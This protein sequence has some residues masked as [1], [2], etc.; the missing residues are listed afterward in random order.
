LLNRA[1]SGF[2][3]FF[4]STN[5]FQGFDRPMPKLRFAN[6]LTARIVG[7]ARDRKANVAVIFA[8]AMVPTIY[9][10][11]MTLDYSQVI[12]KR[13]QL[14]A[15]ADAAVIA[16][17]TPTMLTQPTAN[18]VTAA[19]NVFNATASPQG[20]PLPGL[21]GTPALN[22][23]VTNSG[24][25]RTA[26]VSYTAAS[27]NNFPILLGT[28]V[29]AFNGSSS[30]SASGAPNINFYLLLDDS[31]SMAIAANQSDINTLMAATANNQDAP[32]GC[33]FACHQSNV[34]TT[35]NPKGEP[36]AAA[37]GGGDYLGIVNSQGKL[38]LNSQGLPFDNYALARSLSLTL[39]IDLVAQAVASLMTTAQATQLKN[40]NT[41]QAAIYT[42]DFGLNTI[43]APSGLPS[44]NLSAAG[45]QA[46]NNIQVPTVYAN[47]WL[48]SSNQNN[49]TNTNFSSALQ[50]LNT[51]M[52]NPGGGT[53]NKGDT[54]QEV[55]FLV[56]DGVE[57]KVVTSK[58]ACSQT[59]VSMP[60]ASQFRC[61]QPFDT[62]WC[63]TVKN[64]GIRVAVLYTEYLALP[65]D[66]W[67]LNYDG[68][69][70]GGIAPFNSPGPSTGLI[71]TNLQSCASP[72]L[73]YDVQTGGDITAALNNLFLLVVASAAHLTQ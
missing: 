39:R 27:T 41:Y 64:R 71:A 56:T 53:S 29:W 25:V 19:T 31:P 38:L 4:Q 43:Y 7:L 63:T 52:P 16:A 50:T 46:A 8:V 45:T 72:G 61:Q 65:T 22:V 55:V 66:G 9:L 35:S 26:T 21:A 68:T 10:L 60:T 15:A 40:N 59:T 14:N 42:F 30:A 18:A 67:Y 1:A 2:V 23:S 6:H 49:D 51:I 13:A 20:K 58:A 48:T 37:Q 73:F 62:T 3:K 32:N 69:A 70:G 47:N 28:P 57:D 11:G 33:G 5:W 24:L 12:R 36:T 44:A 17:V 54:P 34:A